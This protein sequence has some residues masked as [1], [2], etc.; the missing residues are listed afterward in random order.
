MK[1]DNLKT[2]AEMESFLTGNQPIAFAVAS[3]KDERYEF[4]AGI[5]KRFNYA[6]LKRHDKGAYSVHNRSTIPFQTRAMIE[7]CVW[8]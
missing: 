6:R 1:L 4:I 7:S 3:N 5:L 8:Q 2:I